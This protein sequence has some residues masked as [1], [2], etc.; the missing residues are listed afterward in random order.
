MDIGGKIQAQRLKHGLSQEALADQLGVTR[1]SV[2]KWELG[3][4][5]PDIDKVIM[6]S[7][8]FNVATD[9][10]LLE[11]PHS[12]KV[13]RPQMLHWG[14]YLIVKDFAKSIDFYEKFLSRRASILGSNRFARFHF[15]NGCL[16]SIMNEAHLP[17]HN[18]TGCGDHKFALNLWVKDLLQ[19]HQRVKSLNIGHVTEVLHP[20]S[21]YY[22][23]NLTDPDGNIIEITGEY[24]EG[25]T[26][27]S[28]QSVMH[29]QSCYM[30]MDTAEKF[31]SETDGSKNEDYCCYCWKD[32]QFTTPQTL[33][34]AVEGNIPW[35]KGEGESDDVARARIMEVFPKLKR[36]ASA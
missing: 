12:L 24:Y 26:K 25:G 13:S 8:F 18:Y 19:E 15:D 31:G 21:N 1:Q 27:M 34:E 3:Q 23:F 11:D 35:W 29:C 30:P 5:L 6:L 20:H 2:S 14:L 17:G 36:W 16:L 32:S 4:A 33:A 28:N 9:E 22:F 10:L 7:K